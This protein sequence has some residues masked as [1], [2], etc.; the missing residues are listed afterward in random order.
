MRRHWRVSREGQDL[1]LSDSGEPE[2]SLRYEVEVLKRVA[3]TGWPVPRMLEGPALLEGRWWTLAPF[4][5]GDPP[6]GDEP[7]RR[8][9]LLAEFHA[10]LDG[11]A[12]VGQRSGFRRAELILADPKVELAVAATVRRFPKETAIVRWHW[13]RARNRLEGIDL[14]ARK[15]QLVHG[16]FTAWNLRFVDGG[17]SAILD[18]ELAHEDHRVAEFCLAWRG[19]HD[20]VVHAYD[21]VIPL[22]PEEWSMLTPIWWLYL[23]DL[24]CDSPRDDP[25]ILSKLMQRSPLMGADRDAFP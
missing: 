22:E 15:G 9:R 23:I 10:S 3:A 6:N 19:K 14:A 21:Q 24:W 5:P 18:F 8:G 20:A 16:D 4:L 25:W 1:V 7:A 17:L 11:L 2:A 13:E 12:S